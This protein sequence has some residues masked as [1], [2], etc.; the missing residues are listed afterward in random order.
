MRGGRAGNS[1]S[2]GFGA[3]EDVFEVGVELSRVG[4]RGERV[5]RLATT[6]LERIWIDVGELHVV[7][8]S[9]DNIV[10][11]WIRNG[12]INGG[13]YGDSLKHSLQRAW[14]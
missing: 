11:T 10:L 8:S 3:A 7:A 5:R 4:W 1:R 6:Y 9:I 2:V 12:A 13:I 14:A